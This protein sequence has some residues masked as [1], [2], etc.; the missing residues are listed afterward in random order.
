[1]YHSSYGQPKLS[2]QAD[3]TGRPPLDTDVE[4]FE[5]VAHILHLFLVHLPNSNNLFCETEPDNPDR[6]TP[7]GI[8]GGRY[9]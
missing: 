9:L 6:L 7:R 3:N 2:V 5:S 8:R 1:M 4:R